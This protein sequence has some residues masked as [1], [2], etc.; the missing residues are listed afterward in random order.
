MST[1]LSD[2]F[3]LPDSA[4]GMPAFF[5]VMLASSGSRRESYQVW[6]DPVLHA[7]NPGSEVFFRHCHRLAAE[8][9]MSDGQLSVHLS[10]VPYYCG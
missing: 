1:S 10:T 6:S 2:V 4:S 5:E 9:L 8:S 7:Y 3:Q